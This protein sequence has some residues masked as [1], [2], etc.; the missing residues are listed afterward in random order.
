MK[1]VVNEAKKNGLNVT[2]HAI[3]NEAIYNAAKAGVNS[4][5]HA[6][7][8]AD[9][10]LAYIKEK[11]ITVVPTYSNKKIA[12]E[13]FLKSGVS[14]KDRRES[15]L[16]RSQNRQQQTLK[17]LLNADI[18]IVFGSDF[19][20]KVSVSRGKA[21]K[22]SFYAFLEADIPLEKALQ[23]ATYNGGMHLGYKDKLG[24]LKKGAV[25]DIIAVKGSLKENYKFLDDCNFIMKN[26]KVIKN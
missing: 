18:K 26:G 7:T 19:Y 1:S 11:N 12:D 2:A 23:F 16:K 21:A 9:S 4:I 6:Y 10:T 15:I 5:E 25:A 17:R 8:F 22:N 3:T 14:N 13:L 24:V 20:S